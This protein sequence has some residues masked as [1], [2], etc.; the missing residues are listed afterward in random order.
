MTENK[1]SQ[2]VDSADAWYASLSAYI[3][4]HQTDEPALDGHMLSARK[5]WQR[6]VSGGSLLA[7]LE[8][9][10]ERAHDLYP[11]LGQNP[12]TERVFVFIT[13][14]PGAVAARELIDE[15]S[16][17]AIWVDQ[18]LWRSWLEDPTTDHDDT[19]QWHYEFW[20]VWHRNVEEGWTFERQGT[21]QLWVHEEGFALD[22]GLGSG[23]QHVWDWDGAQMILREQDVTRWVEDAR[24]QP[25][26]PHHH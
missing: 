26:A 2:G 25:N 19:F 23:S 16:N 3:E 24:F 22:D 1:S 6:R 17:R 9:V 11:K 20:S 12:V 13:D 8:F 5:S 15:N 7:F 18:H 4:R 21:K 10:S 14:K